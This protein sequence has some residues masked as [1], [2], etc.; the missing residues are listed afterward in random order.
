MT[1]FLSI[2]RLRNELEAESLLLQSAKEKSGECLPELPA[3]ILVSSL[4]VLGHLPFLL[5][6]TPT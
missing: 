2:F 1:A 5:H 6:H 3:G 4:G